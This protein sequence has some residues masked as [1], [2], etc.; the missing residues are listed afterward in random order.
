MFLETSPRISEQILAILFEGILREIPDR[1]FE[2][3]S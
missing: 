3:K 2:K 1:N